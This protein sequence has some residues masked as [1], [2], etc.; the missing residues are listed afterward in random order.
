MKDYESRLQRYQGVGGDGGY[1]MEGIE[2]RNRLATASAAA[3]R[4]AERIGGAGDDVDRIESL[5]AARK[6]SGGGG[7]VDASRDPRRRR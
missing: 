7:S 5:H 6:S 2:K 1:A 4:I 3:A